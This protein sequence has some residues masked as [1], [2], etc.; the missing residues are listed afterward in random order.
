M[1][2]RSGTQYLAGLRD[3]REVWYAGERVPDVTTHPAFAAGAQTIAQLYNLQHDP[4]HREILTVASP[5][6]GEPV[7]RSFLRP[8]AIDDLVQ[9]RTMMARWA[10]MSCGM[11]GQSPD[12]MNVGLM[13]LAAAHDFFAQ[14]DTRF[15]IHLL[16]YYEACREADRC[17]A[18][19]VPSL[20]RPAARAD[21][22]STEHTPYPHVVS[23]QADGLV[24]RGACM[25]ATIAPFADDLVICGGPTLHPGEGQRALVCAVPVA[26]AGL[27]L[28]CRETAGRTES[29]FDHPLATRFA[30]MDCLVL[31]DD[32]L[33]PWERVFLHANVELYN[34]LETATRFTWQ[35][36]HQ[37]TTRYIAKTT[38]FLGVA[39]LLSQAIGITDFRHVQEKLGEIV[40]YLE[41]LRSCLRRSEVDAVD[42]NGVF[43]PQG[44]AIHAA[45]RLFPMMHS[46]MIEILQLL[47]AGGYMMTPSERDLH[48]PVA[49]AIDA[50]YQGAGVPAAERI[51]LFRLAWDMVGDN[52]GARQQ[53]YERHFAG[54]SGSLM[55]ARYLDY[56]MSTAVER[57]QTLLRTSRLS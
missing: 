30:T 51:Q 44:D 1:A 9:R 27:S 34:R 14:A 3:G 40:T 15:G 35:V 8:G 23:Q 48:S 46:R 42:C 43:Y 6:T 36:G 38:L 17:L 7:G 52:F 53:L 4:K 41:V 54:D 26:T 19:I 20:D 55:A 56:D 5:K 39:H 31:F 13:S 25:L 37:V 2:V 24:V 12:Y 50:Y 45:L 57:V 21:A 28:V 22:T 10:E 49:G 11:L 16:R 29:A 32:V 47:G 18:S 33:I